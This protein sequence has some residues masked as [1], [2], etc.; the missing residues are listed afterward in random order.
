MKHPGVLWLR[1]SYSEEEPWT[2]IDIQ[3]R[4]K[5]VPPAPITAEVSRRETNKLQDL[6]K[7]IPYLPWQ[8]VSFYEGLEA[9]TSPESDSEA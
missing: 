5:R 2:K 8:F 6:R 1:F 7:M 3:K 9:C 4:G